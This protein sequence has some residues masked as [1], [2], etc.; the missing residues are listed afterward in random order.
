MAETVEDRFEILKCPECGAQKVNL[1]D[2]D[3]YNE[4]WKIKCRECGHEFTKPIK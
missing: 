4:I 3:A 1:M 2:L